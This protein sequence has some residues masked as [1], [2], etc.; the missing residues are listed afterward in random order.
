MS[1]GFESKSTAALAFQ[2]DCHRRIGSKVI[3]AR[4][5]RGRIRYRRAIRKLESLGIDLSNISPVELKEAL[6]RL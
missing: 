6:E 2:G 5:V 4:H 3:V 1:R